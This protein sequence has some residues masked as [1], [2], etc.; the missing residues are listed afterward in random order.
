ESEAITLGHHG[1]E[2]M[3][4]SALWYL[5]VHA[6]PPF[7]WLRTQAVLYPNVLILTWIA[8]TGGRGVVTLDL[9]NCTEVR[10]APSPSHPSARDDVGSVAARLQSADL[11]ETLCPFQLLYTDGVERLGTDTARE[12]VRWVGAIWDVLA[13]IARGP[14]RALTDASESEAG[15]L[16]RSS[17]VRS[18]SSEGSATT[19]FVAPAADIAE[20][21]SVI[22][23]LP[24]E[25][26]DDMSVKNLM[27]PSRTPSLRRTASM[28]DLELE[29]DIDRALGRT[30]A[31]PTVTSESDSNF[32]SPPRTRSQ[33]Y[34]DSDGSGYRTPTTDK[35]RSS[36]YSPS[37]VTGREDTTYVPTDTEHSTVRGVRIVADSIS[38]RGSTSTRGDGFDALSTGYGSTAR[39][40]G[41][42][43]SA[44]YS[45][46]RTLSAE[47][48]A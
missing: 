8:P 30:P 25:T 6:P 44:T 9:V 39:S 11:A 23:Y 31:P 37:N 26:A 35:A 48:Q 3:R 27:P 46:R 14:P 4:I 2:P 28:A 13:T 18:H 47:A 19:S 36:R 22:S 34:S 32:L 1:Q 42:V 41:V 24:L 43:S 7:E 17:S 16:Q 38:F 45:R 10:S 21:A 33:R 40:E 15:T 20:T 12:R 29:A 5:N